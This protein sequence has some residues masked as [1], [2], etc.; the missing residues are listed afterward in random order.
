MAK[1]L[2]GGPLEGGELAWVPSHRAYELDDRQPTSES[3]TVPIL[4]RT[5]GRIHQLLLLLHSATIIVSRDCTSIVDYLQGGYVWIDSSLLV[6]VRHRKCYSPP[7]TF[8]F[9]PAS[10]CTTIDSQ[11]FAQT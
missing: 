6:C 4:S 9:C 5:D 11:L 10:G 1:R 7:T 8:V 3:R 2:H